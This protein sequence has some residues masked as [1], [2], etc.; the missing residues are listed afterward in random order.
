MKIIHTADL[1]LGQLIYQN[2]DRVDEHRHFFRQL[3][4]WCIDEQPDALIVSGDVFD[5]QQPSAATRKFFTDAFV[6]IRHACPSMHIVITAGN[7]DSASRI[8]ADSS[9]WEI[10]ET[11]L[12][13]TPPSALAERDVLEKYIVRLENGYIIA[14]PYSSSS[15]NNQI[16]A[17][18]D[19]IDE[20][21][22]SLKP[23]V[24]MGHVAVTG[25]D[26]TGHNFEIGTLRTTDVEY[27]GKGADYVALGHIH[28]PQTIGHQEDCMK[29]EAHYPTPVIRYSGSALHVS[30]DEQYPH[31]VSLVEIDRHGGE[32]N[33]RQLRIDELLHFHVLPNNGSSFTDADEAIAEVQR[34]AADGYSG[35]FRLRMSYSTYL[36]AD[37]NQRIY[38]IKEVAEGTLRYNPKIEWTGKMVSEEEAKPTFEVAELQ[39][40]TDPMQF[41]AK[42]I[43]RYEGL[44]ADEIREM[45][46]EVKRVL[47]E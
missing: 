11:T 47:N 20:E 30:C 14:I 26:V 38:E 6:S 12:I 27:F 15:S 17:M 34:L 3:E 45:F 16:Q 43:D 32:V 5:I 40:M 23:V 28:K 42:T 41:I 44:E 1:H 25:S 9:I 13:G 22:K 18:L 24:V 4:K 39:Q 31:T 10:A 19:I 35:Y 21:N 2:Y 36:P 7:H 46:D 8:Q 29:E 33:I 37:F